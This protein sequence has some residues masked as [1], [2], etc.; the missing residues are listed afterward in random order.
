MI[1]FTPL[2]KII[3][4][5]CFKTENY[6]ALLLKLRLYYFVPF[7]LR[8]SVLPAIHGED[9]RQNFPVKLLI[10]LKESKKLCPFLN[11]ILVLEKI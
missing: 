11:T 1:G 10:A 5:N 6:E 8:M 3:L 4:R 9:D 7:K 2:A